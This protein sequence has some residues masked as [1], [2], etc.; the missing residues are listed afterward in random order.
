MKIAE[1]RY[2]M[3]LAAEILPL[4]RRSFR[5][6]TEA[7]G[8]T[9]AFHGERDFD[10]EPDMEQ[11]QRLQDSGVLVI[12]TLRDEAA[13]VGYLVA[14]VY[15][16]LHHKKMVCANVDTLYVEPDHRTYSPVLIEAFEK[17]MR[18]KQVDIIGWPTH[19][20]G[21]IYEVLK[22][23]GYVGDDTIMEKRLCVS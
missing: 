9:C 18:E 1:E 5:E 22:T 19:I 12:L 11:Y 4:G 3:D 23:R 13:L 21:P 10:I 17:S 7:K 6:S 20:N 15:R 14:A 2:S 16:S 8:E